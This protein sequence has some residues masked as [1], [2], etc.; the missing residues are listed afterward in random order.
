MDFRSRVGL[1]ARSSRPN[2]PLSKGHTLAPKTADQLTYRC[3]PELSAG[4]QAESLQFFGRHGWPTPGICLTLSVAL[5]LSMLSGGTT[6][7]PIGL[8]P[9]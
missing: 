2:A 9:I 8:I 1:T 3:F 4:F 6:M 7:M 5:K